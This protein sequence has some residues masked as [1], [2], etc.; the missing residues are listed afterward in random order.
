MHTVYSIADADFA[1]YNCVLYE[2]IILAWRKRQN[3]TVEKPSREQ[4]SDKCLQVYKYQTKQ[5]SSLHHSMATEKP[6]SSVRLLFYADST[7]C[8]RSQ[9][10]Q[11]KTVPLGGCLACCRVWCHDL[12]HGH[13][14]G[15]VSVS[16]ISVCPM[17]AACSVFLLTYSSI[18]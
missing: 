17:A 18:R 5:N 12:G 4:V 3:K 7:W 16:M 10:M 8:I 6:C 13:A 1:K 15:S 2:S 9:K 14:V 11:T